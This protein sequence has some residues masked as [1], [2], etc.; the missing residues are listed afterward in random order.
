MEIGGPTVR[1][2]GR[3]T[4][5]S[6]RKPTMWPDQPTA[7]ALA[8]SAYSRISAQPTSQATSSPITA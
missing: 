4:P 6:S 1:A 7:T 8:P 3:C 5:M 2:W